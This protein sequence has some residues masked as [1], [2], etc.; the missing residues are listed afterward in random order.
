MLLKAS[1][2]KSA[3]ECREA[4]DCGGLTPLF[5][6]GQG[7]MNV[8]QRPRAEMRKRARDARRRLHL[9]LPQSQSGVE[10][11]QSKASRHA[12]RGFPHSHHFTADTAL[13]GVMHFGV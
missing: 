4:L 2:H 5:H 11:P 8:L 13:E 7:V 9:L 10:P 3:C 6:I 12:P 1:L